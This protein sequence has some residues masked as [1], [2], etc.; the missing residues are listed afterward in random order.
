MFVKN[1]L[2]SFAMLVSHVTLFLL[3]KGLVDRRDP[4]LFVFPITPFIKF[5]VSKRYFYIQV[6]FF[7]VVSF[8]FAFYC[9]KHVFICLMLCL[10]FLSLC[11]LLE[12]F[13]IPSVIHRREKNLCLP[14]G[15]HPEFETST[16]KFHENF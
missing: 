13:L 8:R 5:H 11:F 9:L 15:T 14:T 1:L 7:K 3:I 12:N 6:F 2:N 4:D 10:T 16:S